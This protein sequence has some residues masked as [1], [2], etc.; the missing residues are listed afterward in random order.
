MKLL[1]AAADVNSV[2]TTIRIGRPLSQLT[3]QRPGW[4]LRLRSLHDCSATDL[5]WADILIL[6]RGLTRRAWRLIRAMHASG[7]RVVYE[8]DDLLSEMPPSLI[9]HQ[10]VQR[11]LPW[12]RRCIAAADIV[13]VS[14]ARL[15]RTLAPPRWVEIPNYGDAAPQASGASRSADVAGTPMTLLFASSDRVPVLQVALALQELQALPGRIGPVLAV[16]P[17][18][19]DLVA[20]GVAV[21][22]LPQMARVDFLDLLRSLGSVLAVIPIGSTSFDACKSAIK[23]F[24]YALAEIPVICSNRPPYSDVAHDGVDAVLVEDRAETWQ[25]AIET[26]IDEPVRIAALV[27]AA[28]LAVAAR[29]S[30]DQTVLA[31]SA[32]LDE[33][34]PR[35]AAAQAAANPWQR[36]I[37]A[38]A[39]W[40]RRFNRNRLARRAAK[41]S[42]KDR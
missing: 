11:R 3:A 5:E 33:I 36:A 21:R 6:Q 1:G 25:A 22:R 12:L 30:L 32:V 24:D 26:A 8:I 40:L 16:G 29:H 28:A 18:A 4:E 10:A 31:W 23:F 9:H 38:A 27:A 35:T 17:V 20:A 41:R 19:D 7:G 14:T 39:I 37:E 34:G 15:G 13:S 42:L 2:L